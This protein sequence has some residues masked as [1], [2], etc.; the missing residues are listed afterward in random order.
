MRDKFIH[1]INRQEEEDNLIG[2]PDG[3]LHDKLKNEFVNH[4]EIIRY[5][6]DVMKKRPKD[7]LHFDRFDS[8]ELIPVRHESEFKIR[9]HTTSQIPYF[10][11]HDYYEI[12]YV[13]N[14]S[15]EQHIGERREEVR[16][17]KGQAC[18]LRPGIGHIMERTG[19][20]DI[21]FKMHIPENIFIKSAP[22]D[23]YKE[24]EIFTD[25]SEQAEYQV[26]K[27]LEETNTDRKYKDNAIINYLSLF[28]IEA[29]RGEKPCY[30]RIVSEVYDYIRNNMKNASLKDYS[31]KIGYNEVYVGKTIKKY[32]LKSFTDI[33]IDMRMKRVFELLEGTDMTVERI[34][35]EVG[36]ANLSGL[37]RQFMA[38]SGM[39]PAEYRNTIK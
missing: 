18:L 25:M 27:L 11:A 3:I 23:D 1:T 32:A 9:K 29:E 24:C 8:D 5:L 20:K 13:L 31:E 30:N 34:A 28:L 26:L 7:C 10:H 6:S 16:I 37:H 15:S 21:I 14:G 12:I 17:L 33:L 2:T 35:E 38:F 4:E 19:D 36:Y 22:R 39:T